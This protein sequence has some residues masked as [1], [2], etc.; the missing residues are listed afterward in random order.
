MTTIAENFEDM[1]IRSVVA[2][3]HTDSKLYMEAAHTN[4]MEQAVAEDL[5]K[6]GMLLVKS[7]DNFY[8][9]VKMAAE[10]V[11]IM[12]VVSS[13]VSMVELSTKATD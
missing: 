6:K 9:P 3:A 7:G 8:K 11:Y 2:F 10:K 4:Q 1:H 5:F 13:A 12:D